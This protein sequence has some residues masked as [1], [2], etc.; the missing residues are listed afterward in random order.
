M[1]I[2]QPGM[3]WGGSSVRLQAGITTTM[4]VASGLDVE[5]VANVV[6]KTTELFSFVGF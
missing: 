3:N 5:S 2:N 6:D 1:R 4:L